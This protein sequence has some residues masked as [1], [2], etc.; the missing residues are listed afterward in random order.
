[1][2]RKKD[3]YD[4]WEDEWKNSYQNPGDYL[5]GEPPSVDVSGYSPHEAPYPRDW[6]SRQ[7]VDMTWYAM[8]QN[9]RV[10]YDPDADDEGASGWVPAMQAM[11]RDRRNTAARVQVALAAGPNPEPQLVAAEPANPPDPSE[12]RYPRAAYEE[13]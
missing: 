7:R 1:M 10:D 6:T 9:I 2:A 11:T 5:A 12:P 4:R 13:W 8:R 3:E